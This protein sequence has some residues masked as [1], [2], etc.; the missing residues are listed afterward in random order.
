MIPQGDNRWLFRR[1]AAVPRCDLAQSHTGKEA[2]AQAAPFFCIPFETAIMDV[3]VYRT[4]SS[5]SAM[6]LKRG[7]HEKLL[8]QEPR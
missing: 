3:A 7:G 6:P 1:W 4:G 5:P 8:R 2:V